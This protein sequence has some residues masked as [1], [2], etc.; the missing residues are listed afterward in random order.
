MEAINLGFCQ[1]V[2]YNGWIDILTQPQ[3]AFIVDAIHSA[4]AT[5][6]MD[7]ESQGA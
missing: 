6:A 7:E 3:S 4:L 2:H 1:S 5:E